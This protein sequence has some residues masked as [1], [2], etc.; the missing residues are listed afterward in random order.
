MSVTVALIA[1]ISNQD[2]GTKIV[3]RH[4]RDNDE[5]AKVL[6]ID[7][8]DEAI[9]I[10]YKLDNPT[11]KHGGEICLAFMYYY[12]PVKG[13]GMCFSMSDE[14]TLLKNA[15]V[16]QISG[17]WLNPKPMILNPD[18]LKNTRLDDHIRKKVDFKDDIQQER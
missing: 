3:I 9:N 6:Q 14:S 8:F 15:N 2:P 1:F 16:E 7:N 17:Y 12:P 18:H 4:F 10:Y 11:A 5:L 13:G